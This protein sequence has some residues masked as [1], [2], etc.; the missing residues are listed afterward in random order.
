LD[1]GGERA[2]G[3]RPAAIRLHNHASH[4][5]AILII[6]Y[7]STLHSDDG[8]GP[9]IA[10]AVAEWRTPGLATIAPIQLTPELAEHIARAD[11]VF[12]IDAAVKPIK[13]HNPHRSFGLARLGPAHDAHELGQHFGDPRALL[14]LAQQ[15]YGA[16]PKAWL[17]TVPGTNFGLGESLS[18]QTQR[19]MDEV[20]HYLRTLT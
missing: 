1:E 16:H 9:R 14:A 18:P 17:I 12:F 2:I 4:R 6:G 19:G 10:E 5:A 11:E 7:G 20:L 13:P 3:H 15:L 8:V